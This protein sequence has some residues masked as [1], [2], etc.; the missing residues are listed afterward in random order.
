[1]K[2]TATELRTL[3]AKQGIKYEY[4]PWVERLYRCSAHMIVCED[5]IVL[6]SYNTFVAH[7]D[8][9]N[10][11][12]YVYDYYSA[13][14]SQHISKFIKFCRENYCVCEVRY[15]YERSDKMI[16]W[17]IRNRHKYMTGK[18]DLVDRYIESDFKILCELP[19]SCEEDFLLMSANYEEH[20]K[21]ENRYYGYTRW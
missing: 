12:I 14:T 1:M 15:L 5:V 6:K 3:V 19:K 21:M 17:D 9:D 8:I 13:T 16:V 7:Y 10:G 20:Q 4:G 11:I 18:K 2:V